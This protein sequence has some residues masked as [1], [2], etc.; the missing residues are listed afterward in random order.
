VNF[1]NCLEDNFFTQHVEV[2][3]RNDAI[4]DLV[5]SDEPNMV[6]ELMD[7]GPF[8]DGDHNSLLWKLAVKTQRESEDR[9]VFD[10]SKVDIESIRR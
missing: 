9:E 7:I 5:I 6:T 2:P 8:A 10:Y 1:F 4:L 3:T